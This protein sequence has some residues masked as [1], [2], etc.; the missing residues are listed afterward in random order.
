VNCSGFGFLA[1]SPQ[2]NVSQCAKFFSAWQNW[3][4]EQFWRTLKE[5]LGT[6]ARRFASGARVLEEQMHFA[7]ITAMRE[8]LGEFQVFYNFSRPH[9]SLKG[10]TPAQVWQA[11]IKQ[12][13]LRHNNNKQKRGI[14]TRDS[15]S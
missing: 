14:R 13:K 11:Q 9:Q 8:V 3:W 1:D 4:I 6:N 5:A 15:P 7:S 2:G 12:R 10:Q